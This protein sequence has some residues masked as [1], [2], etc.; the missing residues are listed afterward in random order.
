MNKIFS[1]IYGIVFIALSVTGSLSGKIIESQ[2]MKTIIP[3]VNQE[4]FVFFNVS[5]T[6]YTSSNALGDRRW[7]EYFTERVNEQT[8][9]QEVAQ[10]LIDKVKNQM[11][12]RIPKKGI[13]EMTPR[14]IEYFQ[15]KHIVVFGITQKRMT[16]SYAD[17]FGELVHHYLLGLNI[18]LEKSLTYFRMPEGKSKEFSFAYGIVFTNKEAVGPALL[19]FLSQCERKPFNVVMVD[20]SHLSL[21]SAQQALESLGIPFTG[22]RY[23]RADKGEIFDPT[24]GTI[25][26]FALMQEDKVLSD[27]EALNRMPVDKSIN[28]EGFLDKYIQQELK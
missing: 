17:N 4:S 7:R 2:E 28:Y 13:E 18:D 20:N 6:L 10:Q 26:F 25:E 9:D 11:V 27:E 21:E 22:I 8:D 16:P 23:G 19:S 1:F 5:G 15:D 12:N 3:F 14:L 24:L